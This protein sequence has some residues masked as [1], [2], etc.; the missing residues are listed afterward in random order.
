MY[1][2]TT[3]KVLELTQHALAVFGVA[4]AAS[5]VVVALVGSSDGGFGLI[6]VGVLFGGLLLVLRLYR[7][8]FRL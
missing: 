7:D 5:R 8:R 2:R 4:F 3:T 6:A 1:G